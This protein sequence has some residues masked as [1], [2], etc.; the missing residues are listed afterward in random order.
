MVFKCQSMSGCNLYSLLIKVQD[1]LKRE[2]RNDKKHL[3][4]CSS[5]SRKR[6]QKRRWK[7]AALMWFYYRLAKA[8]H[9]DALLLIKHQQCIAITYWEMGASISAQLIRESQWHPKT[10]VYLTD[11]LSIAP[12]Q[13]SAEI[14]R[15]HSNM[16]ANVN[17]KSDFPWHQKWT[18][19][20]GSSLDG[21]LTDLDA[22]M[23]PGSRH[24]QR[25]LQPWSQ[26]ILA[27]IFI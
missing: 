10:T 12:N 27:K 19:S 18:H 1:S 23:S 20:R 16:S 4:E 15:Y 7:D 13:K 26:S 2:S 9:F 5:T 3:R 21:S 24:P 8:H 6:H 14:L 17:S 25:A 11:S 22:M